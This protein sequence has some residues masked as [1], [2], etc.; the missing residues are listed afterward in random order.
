MTIL[1]FLFGVAVAAGLFFILADILKLPRLSTE[2][3]LL[4]AGRTEKKRMKSLDAL[5][6]GW[7][8]KLSKYIRMDEYK[9]HR[10]E[11]TLSAAGMDMTPEVYLAYTILKPAAALL[12]VIPCLLIF[13]LLSPIVVLLSILLYFK[14]SRKAEEKVT[15]RREKIEGELPRFV[16][17]VEQELGASRDVL[18]ILEN[19]KRHA[20]PDFAREL[21]VLTADMRSSSYEAALVRF[22]GRLASPMLSDIVRGLIGVLRGDDGRVYFQMLS[23]DMK[24]LELQRLK[25]QAAKDPAQDP[26]VFL[27]HA[28]LL[29]AHLHCG[30]P[31][32]DPHLDGRAVRMMKHKWK[33]RS[34][35]GYIDT[36]VL[37]LCAMLVIA[38]AVKVLPVYV[39]KQ[40][41]DTFAVELVREAEITGRVGSETTSR[42]QVLSER[43]EID[44]DIRWSRTGRIQL[45]EEVTVTLTMDV[46]IGFGG[47]G[48]FPIEL[49]AQASG[50]SEVYWK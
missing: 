50:R 42:A 23:H 35:E 19:Y 22:E 30:H 44:P 41:L 5:F 6:L 1:L 40:Q 27:R 49:T 33:K 2:K 48:S 12:A 14:E 9:R 4:S 13:P 39:A 32:A 8:I 37:I 47:L 31:H 21:D 45:N 26:C 28:G 17:T 38:L 25:A 36:C 24:Q 7:A 43:L 29:H 3:A 20:G 18:T 46:D 10:M 34:G 11:R 16:A 15:E